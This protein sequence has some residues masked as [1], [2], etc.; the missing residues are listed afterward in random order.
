MPMS[1]HSLFMLLKN[2]NAE[3]YLIVHN[4]EL[5]ALWTAIATPQYRSIY[6]AYFY[7]LLRIRFRRADNRQVAKLQEHHIHHDYVFE[8]MFF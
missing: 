7:C 3:E 8:G 6:I 4:G 5:Y 2:Y 1:L